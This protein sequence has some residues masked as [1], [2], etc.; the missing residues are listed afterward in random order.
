MSL[1][2]V[3]DVVE[4]VQTDR[5]SCQGRLARSEVEGVGVEGVTRPGR[6]VSDAREPDLGPVYRGSLPIRSGTGAS[7][8][9]TVGPDSPSGWSVNDPVR[10]RCTDRYREPFVILFSF[11][12]LKSPL[13]ASSA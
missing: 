12:F 9:G 3:T 13:S 2:K 11:S 5:D 1:A 10:R 7:H 6:R 4:Q 8:P